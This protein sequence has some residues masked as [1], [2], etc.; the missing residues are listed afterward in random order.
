LKLPNDLA[1]AY[2]GA[3]R[4]ANYAI[5][6][7]NGAIDF[8]Y[9]RLPNW[10]S[11]KDIF[12]EA[13]LLNAQLMGAKEVLSPVRT[14]LIAANHAMQG[15]SPLTYDDIR[16]SAHDIA[17]HFAEC[18]GRNVHVAYIRA[19]AKRTNAR[20]DALLVAAIRTRLQEMAPLDGRKLANALLAEAVEAFRRRTELSDPSDTGNKRS[21]P[22]PAPAYAR[23]GRLAEAAR[24]Y[25]IPKSRLSEAVKKKLVK[26]HREG[27][28]TLVDFNSVEQ[29]DRTRRRG[30]KTKKITNTA[31]VKTNPR[32][33]RNFRCKKCDGTF[34]SEKVEPI[35][36]GC[37][38]PDNVVPL[39]NSSD[40]SSGV[41]SA[42]SR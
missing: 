2:F 31:A 39:P 19:L 3:H 10:K 16:S 34:T 28:N 33:V 22:D 14:E 1:A 42:P 12:T 38:L 27:K 23:L 21:G 8:Q 7:V 4:V 40:R 37:K 17:L 6:I 30:P 11:A 15:G 32:S 35:C 9:A 18:V 20:T 24:H 41:R 36:P 29:W 13:G 25:K 5:A 26:S